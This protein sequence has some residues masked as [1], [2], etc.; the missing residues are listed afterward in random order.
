MHRPGIRNQTNSTST[1]ST[2]SNEREANE[3]HRLEDFADQING[4]F[5]EMDANLRFINFSASVQKI[6][7]LKPE[8]H[9]GKTRQDIGAPETIDSASWQEHLEILRLHKPFEHFR[10]LRRSPNGDQ[11]MSTSG[12]PVFGQNGEF[13]GYR[14]IAKDISAEVKANT[15]LSQLKSAIENQA[16][17]FSLWDSDDRLVF[18]NRQFRE[19][20]QLFSETLEIGTKFEDHIRAGLAVGAYLDA[21]GNEDAWL[22]EQ[23]RLHH[24]SEEGFEIQRQDGR[25]ILI[26]DQRL[27]DGSTATVSIDVTQ[28]AKTDEAL[29]TALDDAETAN[30][31]K[32]EFLANMSHELRTPLNAIIGFSEIIRSGL[33]GP[34]ERVKDQEYA[35]DIYDSGQLLLN[36]INDILDISKVELG[37]DELDEAG[38]KATDLVNSVVVLVR[39]RAHKT[40]VKIQTGIADDLPMLFVDEQKLKQILINLMSNSIK[41]TPAGGSVD[42]RV[43]R[44]AENGFLFEVTD[45][46]IGIEARDIAKALQPFGQIDSALNRNHAGTGLGL[47]LAKKLTEMHGGTLELQSKPDVGTTVTIKLPAERTV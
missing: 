16:E 26:R 33:F 6:T 36:L 43:W 18:A 17:T 25:R 46:S 40:R 3:S 13:K 20:N 11:T 19:I 35:N 10:F 44:D 15:Q 42:L 21:I 4:W 7:G 45:T 14:G 5:W 22:A 41:F 1:V 34:D 8:W 31:S 28:I 9:Y 37:T 47:P 24:G 38:I 30:R 2:R 32:S 39:E 12:K 29:R 23:L 27:P